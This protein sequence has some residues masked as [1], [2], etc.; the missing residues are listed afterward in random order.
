MLVPA[1]SPHRAR[2]DAK[3]IVELAPVT[4]TI[5]RIVIDE[6][7]VELGSADAMRREASVVDQDSV[8]RACVAIGN[9]GNAA[10]VIGIVR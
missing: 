9:E 5:Y 3:K 10:A 4:R 2:R 1:R 8:L 6:S 7:L